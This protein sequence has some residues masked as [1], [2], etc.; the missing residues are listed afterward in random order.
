VNTPLRQLTEL[1][2]TLRCIVVAVR[3][4]GRIAVT[5]ADDQVL[6][7]DDVYFVAAQEDIQRTFGIFGRDSPIAERI[8]I[9]GGGNIGLKVAQMI[10]ARSDLS[11]ILIERDRVRAEHVADQLA[12]TT[13]LHGDALNDEILGEAGIANADALVAL[14]DDDRA[15]LLAS[16]LAQEAGCRIGIAL[17]KDTVF[18]RIS[19]TLGVNALINPRATTVSSILR[20]VR[21]G[22]IRAVYSVGGG[23]AEVIEAQVMANSPIVGKRICDIAFPAGL[24]VGAILSNGNLVMPKGDTVIRVGDRLVVFAVRDAVGQVEQ[25]FRVSVDFF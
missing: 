14:T 13:V 4:N 19:E 24:I 23:E 11:A 15:N 6:S 3:R 21:R 16:A 22:K 10:E 18:E 12:E 25:L 7:G 9:V 1:F 20:H 8:V 2:S 5:R 17:A